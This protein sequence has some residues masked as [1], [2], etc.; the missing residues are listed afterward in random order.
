[1]KILVSPQWLADRLSSETIL[2]LDATLKKTVNIIGENKKEVIPGAVYFDLDNVFSVQDSELPHT[3]PSF[4]CMS[5][6]LGATGLTPQSKVVVYD[7]Q[8]IYSAPRVWWMLKVMGIQ[9]VYLLDGGL[10]AWKEAGFA[11]WENHSFPMAT[12]DQSFCAQSESMVDKR[13]VFSNI[14]TQQFVVV[15]A[16]PAARFNGVQAEP[17]AGLRCGHIPGSVNIPFT[18][19]LTE[20]K[21]Q[22]QDFLTTLFD[23]QGL[24]PHNSL[25]F[26]CGSGVTAC[27][28]LIAA[29]LAGFTHL[30]VYDGSWAE[31]GADGALPVRSY[32][33]SK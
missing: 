1:M 6:L 14:D 8:G 15:D 11:V 22:S 32:Q 7:Q 31:W 24:L 28:V 33:V 27:I 16:R 26:S 23:R 2:V 12:Q 20:G 19:V 5:A 29:Y 3:F 10:P 9:K 18:E 13:T 30:K 21:Y 25:V 4:S 17:R